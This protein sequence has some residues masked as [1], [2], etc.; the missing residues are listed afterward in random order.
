VATLDEQDVKAIAKETAKILKQDKTDF[1]IPGEDHYL[2]HMRWRQLFGELEL[3]KSKAQERR[4][5]IL[6]WLSISGI[7]VFIWF[8]GYSAL[9]VGNEF[10]EMV[11]RNPPPGAN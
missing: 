4:E 2:D 7:S 8:L 1:W 6:G 11:F 5:K 3:N 9:K 10:L